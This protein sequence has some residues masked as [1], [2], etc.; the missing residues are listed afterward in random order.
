MTGLYRDLQWFI[1]EIVNIRDHIHLVFAL[2]YLA[3][4]FRLLALK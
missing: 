1:G 2:S 4:T 3:A